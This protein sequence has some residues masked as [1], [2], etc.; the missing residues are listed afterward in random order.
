MFDRGCAGKASATVRGIPASL[1]GSRARCSDSTLSF[2]LRCSIIRGWGLHHQVP[3]SEEFIQ[4]LPQWVLCV[5][6]GKGPHIFCLSFSPFP[7][8]SPLKLILLVEPA[9]CWLKQ[10]NFA[11]DYKRGLD[12]GFACVCACV[13]DF[14]P[15][16]KTL[17]YHPLWKLHTRSLLCLSLMQRSLVV[18]QGFVVGGRSLKCFAART[19][20]LAFG[21]L[22][23]DP[24]QQS[25]NLPRVVVIEDSLKG[26]LTVRDSSLCF[27]VCW[28]M[29][30]GLN[31]RV[32]R[33]V[34]FYSA[35]T[36]TWP[37]SLIRSAWYFIVV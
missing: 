37:N 9:L 23:S 36:N 1:S 30:S 4:P 16:P 12:M 3:S 32:W 15:R 13:W 35:A 8:I 21:N 10:D 27:V 11:Y 7:F 34:V 2:R 19:G 22:G 25:D 29:S 20:N 5:V 18:K 31:M 17:N 28:T 33:G 26:C 6:A 14:G 24:A